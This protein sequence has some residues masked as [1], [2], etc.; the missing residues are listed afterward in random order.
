MK[1]TLNWLKE[2]IDTEATLDEITA[3]LTDIGLEVEEVSNPAAALK[4]FI[5]AEIK[6]VNDHPNADKLHILKVDTGTEVLQIVCG[7]PNVHVGLKG[8]LARPGV[9]VPISGETLKVGKIRGVESFGMMCSA[10]ELKLGE[11]HNGILDLET[12]APLG[13]SFAKVLGEDPLIDINVTPNRPDCFGVLG[14]ARDL[15]AAGIGTFKD[16]AAT[17]VKGSFPSPIKVNLSPSGCAIFT[18]RYIRG[19]KNCAS[20]Q[21]LQDRLNAVGLRPISALVDVTNYLNIGRCRPL[22][23]FDATKIKG[24]IEVRYAKEGEKLITL[25]EKE[26][27]LTADMTVIADAEEVL[28][29]AGIMGGE[30]SGVSD[31][32]T[33]VFLESA[34]FEPMNIAAT[35]RALNIESDSRTRFER[36]VDAASAV[37]DN[38]IATRLILELCGGEASEIV[39]AGK[40]PHWQREITFRPQ[41]VN[42]LCGVDVSKA[43]AEKILTALGFTVNGDKVTPPSWRPDIE[44]EADLVEEVMRIYGYDKLPAL[45]MISGEMPKVLLTPRQKKEISA[46]RALAERG[47]FQA[48]TWSFM[49]SEKA[50]LFGSKGVMLGNPIASDLDEMRPSLLPNLIDAAKR[51]ADRG[52][53]NTAL[54]EVGPQFT[55]AKPGEQE[56]MASIVRM[57]KNHSRHWLDAEREADVFDVKEDAIAALAAIDA[58]ISG[59]QVFRTAPSYYHPGRSGALCLGKNVLAYFGE[60]H[61][62]VLKAM[63]VKER[64]VAA[65]VFLD[66]VPAKELKNKNQKTVLMSAFQP[67]SRDFAFIM[68]T[69]IDAEKVLKTAKNVDKNLI[70]DVQVFDLYE[71][72]RLGEGKKSLAIEVTIQPQEKTL[73]DAEIEDISARIVNAVKAATGAELRS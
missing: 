27:T 47:G 36:G 30:K 22:H 1:L 34:W 71:G 24:D 67:L 17:P 48:I 65:E 60:L 46:R 35:G 59:L 26:H 3:K 49:S 10:R 61:P 11:D 21:W 32:T 56:A 15:S 41:R 5:I 4:D 43:E 14:V 52:Y 54:F 7:A 2:Y 28:S 12:D 51:N 33:D 8:V 13:T 31:D 50:K 38:E 18:G 73:T 58:P 57:G 45:S 66:K 53:P 25:D 23:V 42:E 62:N 70:A 69:G 9:I 64:V 63:D 20:P 44:G 29:L 68:D 72:E 16:T 39:I 19:V 40:E 6:E 37:P 55:G